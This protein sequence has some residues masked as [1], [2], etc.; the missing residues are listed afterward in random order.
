MKDLAIYCSGNLGREL[1]CLIKRIDTAS[2][3][4]FLG[5]FDDT[6]DKGTVCE[7]GIILGGMESLNQWP[8][9]LDVVVAIGVPDG[10]LHIVSK[11]TNHLISFPNIISPDV[12]LI[13]E[14]TLSMGKGN[15][16]SP[17]CLI[18]CDVK[19]GDFNVIN[20]YTSI[21]HDVVIGN[22][23]SIMPAVRISGNVN[24]GNCNFFGASSVILQK[25]NVGSNMVLGA[26]GVLLDN[27]ENG[28]KYVGVPA[29][30]LNK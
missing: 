14:N 28:K 15:I 25:L 5:Y 12:Y 3:W 29:K 17:R 7:Y 27:A 8:T 6:K 23:N 1:Y 16:I 2:Y 21:G 20:W 24:I 13:D 26:G 11:I 4:N 19:I 22:Y 10:M 9:P 18:S 30:P